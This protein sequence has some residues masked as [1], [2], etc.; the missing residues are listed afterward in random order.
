MAQ[1]V[2][3]KEKNSLVLAYREGVTEMLRGWEKMQNAETEFMQRGFSGAIE[4]DD[5][6][7][8]NAGFTYLLIANSIGSHPA[9]KALMDAGHGT[10]FQSIRV[11]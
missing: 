5:L 6:V 9:V 1:T 7:G 2:L 3:S 11:R 8:A 10:N 4:D